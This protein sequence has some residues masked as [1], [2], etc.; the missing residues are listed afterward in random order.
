MP[1]C[2]CPADQLCL[3]FYSP[4]FPLPHRIPT[5]FSLK[6]SESTKLWPF[7]HWIQKTGAKVSQPQQKG[8]TWGWGVGGEAGPCGRG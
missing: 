6:G 2:P 3:F 1:S 5:L 8:E 4:D 7:T